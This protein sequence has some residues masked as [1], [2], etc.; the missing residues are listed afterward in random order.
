[1]TEGDNALVPLPGAE[2]QIKTCPTLVLRILPPFNDLLVFG[3]S[4]RLHQEAK[5]FDEI[6]STNDADLWQLLTGTPLS[7]EAT[8]TS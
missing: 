8:L 2:G 6:I 3:I 1:M 7:I 5:G 4:T